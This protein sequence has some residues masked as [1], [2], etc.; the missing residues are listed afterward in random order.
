MEKWLQMYLDRNP[1][2]DILDECNLS[3]AEDELN[4]IF[5]SLTNE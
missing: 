1:I 3:K 5:R 4:Y 2:Q